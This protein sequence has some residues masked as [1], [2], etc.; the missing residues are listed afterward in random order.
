M[1]NKVIVFFGILLVILSVAWKVFF[2]SWFDRLPVVNTAL[3]LDHDEDNR[4]DLGGEW[5]GATF[6]LGRLELKTKEA[7]LNEIYVDSSFT[8]NSITGDPLFNLKN[9]LVVDRHSRMITS[10]GSPKMTDSYFF[11]PPHV[12]KATYLVFPATFGQPLEVQFVD[13]TKIGDLDVYHFRGQAENIDDTAGY[14][15]LPLVPEKYRVFS[16]TVMNMY[17]EPI[18]G[19][20][21]NYDDRGTSYYVDDKDSR[22]WDIANWRNR[23]TTQTVAQRLIE[24]KDMIR[25]VNI[26]E[27]GTTILLLVLGVILITSRLRR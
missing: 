24:A 14:E 17:V 8:A 13:A 2:L 7:N 18:T 4:F 5:S 3:L 16:R 6:S 11:F 12:K 25:T 22:V 10:K 23:F 15:F 26:M 19:H 9:Q 20:L 21:I 27:N 1:R